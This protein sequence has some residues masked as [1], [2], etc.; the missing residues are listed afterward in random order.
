M[1]EGVDGGCAACML[2]LAEAL[3]SALTGEGYRLS[4]KALLVLLFPYQCV[5]FLPQPG[6]SLPAF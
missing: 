5:A 6:G 3:A 4:V 1:V 2:A